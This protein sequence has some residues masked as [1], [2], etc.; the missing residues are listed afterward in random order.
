MPKF[1]LA[2]DAAAQQSIEQAV[3]KAPVPRLLRGRVTQELIAAAEDKAREAGRDTVTAEDVV[4]GLLAKM[5]AGLRDKVANAMQQGP[6]ALKNL[7]D[8][9]TNQK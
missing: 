7:E 8:E 9:L 3:A 5:P 1:T 4:E 2:W 6:E